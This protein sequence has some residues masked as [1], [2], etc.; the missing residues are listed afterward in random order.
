MKGDAIGVEA[1]IAGSAQQ[2]D[3]HLGGATEFA[4][5]RPLGAITGDQN[6]AE[7]ARARRRSRQLVEFGRTVESE[8]PEPRL[9]GEG[10]VFFLLYCVAE[11]QPLGGDTVV[12]AELDLAAARHVEAGALALEHR[13]D[14]RCRV[15]LHGVVDAGERQVP[16]QQIVGFCDHVEIDYQARRLGAIFGKETADSFSHV[17]VIH[18]A[19]RLSMV[20]LPDETSRAHDRWRKTHSRTLGSTEREPK[21]ADPPT[22]GG[23]GRFGWLSSNCSDR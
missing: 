22:R 10:N 6:A 3:C 19:R 18:P 7:Y 20:A 14:L 4:R 15:R 21:R 12:E 1:E 11:G 13:D 8:Q 9:M 17:R 23:V 2:L 16:A 5:Q